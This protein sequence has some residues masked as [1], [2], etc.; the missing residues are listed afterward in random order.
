MAILSNDISVKRGTF[1][2]IISKLMSV[3][4]PGYAKNYR[5]HR[6]T[7][8]LCKEHTKCHEHDDHKSKDKRPPPPITGSQINPLFHFPVH[9]GNHPKRCKAEIVQLLQHVC[10]TMKQ[11]D[12]EVLQFSVLQ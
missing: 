6:L 2:I 11:N 9:S 1:K 10:S 7:S 12:L 4:S 5:D 3:G 8:F